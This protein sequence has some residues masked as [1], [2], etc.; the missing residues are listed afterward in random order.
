MG[1]ALGAEAREPDPRAGQMSQKGEGGTSGVGAR[2]ERSPGSAKPGARRAEEP[3]SPGRRGRCAHPVRRRR[4]LPPQLPPDERGVLVPA[5]LGRPALQRELPAGH[6]R[7][8]LPGALPLPPRRR[9]PARQRPVPLCARL[10]GEA[11]RG[12]DPEEG[13]AEGPGRPLTGPPAPA[14]RART[15][16][17]SV[18]LTPMEST[19]ARAAPATTPSPARR[20]TA[21]ACARRVR[22]LGLRGGADWG[23]GHGQEG[24]PERR[25]GVP[26]P[27]LDGGKVAR[28]LPSWKIHFA[29]FQPQK[30]YLR[31]K[32][33][34]RRHLLG[35]HPS[36]SVIKSHKLAGTGRASEIH[37]G[38]AG[39]Q[40]LGCVL[41]RLELCLGGSR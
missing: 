39:W 35:E 18:P 26:G 40:P 32:V 33:Q 23:R 19:A 36:P 8:R 14:F 38:G 37:P 21:P 17:A 13:A 28:P 2:S 24:G 27:Q 15:A 25:G 20:S 11:W 34:A 22:A 10:H 4:P 16:P 29:F 31:L 30:S 41:T 6:A 12:E 1:E 3:G 9:V 5:G 7:A